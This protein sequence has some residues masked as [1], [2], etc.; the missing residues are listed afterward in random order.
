MDDAHSIHLHSS[1]GW[2]HARLCADSDASVGRQPGRRRQVCHDAADQRLGSA[3]RS[4]SG[5]RRVHVEEGRAS[6]HIGV[7]GGAQRCVVIVV[8][9]CDSKYI[10]QRV[11]CRF[12]VANRADQGPLQTRLLEINLEAAPQVADAILANEMFTHYD[13]KRIA[14]V[15][16]CC[17]EQSI[18]LQLIL[19]LIHSCARRLA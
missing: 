17:Y 15:T 16:N 8:V 4:E 19:A 18:G 12:V 11:L 13:R 5:H 10:A 1:L 3:R 9:S 2:L 6:D 7:V 14:T